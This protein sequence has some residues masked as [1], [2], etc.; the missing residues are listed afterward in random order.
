MLPYAGHAI[1]AVGVVAAERPDAADLAVPVGKTGRRSAGVAEAWC[2]HDGELKSEAQWH[3]IQHIH[4]C[5]RFSLSKAKRT[6]PPVMVALS[7]AMH[8]GYGMSICRASVRL[9]RDFRV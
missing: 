2:Q 1:V 4:T 9:P 7:E 6:E 8:P 5:H 3:Q